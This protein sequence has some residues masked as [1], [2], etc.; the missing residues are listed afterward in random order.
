[1]IHDIRV[2]RAKPFTGYQPYET[3]FLKIYV[4]DDSLIKPLTQMLR[5]GSVFCSFQVY[6][7]HITLFM[8]IVNDCSISLDKPIHVSN[9]RERSPA[10]KVSTCDYEYDCTLSDLV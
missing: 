8:K 10:D 5:N 2:V 6:E 4:A 3:L 1:M 9:L 7:T